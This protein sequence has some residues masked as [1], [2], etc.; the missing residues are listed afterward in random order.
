MAP[1]EGNLS[2]IIA[3]IVA[4]SISGKTCS[5][6]FFFLLPSTGFKFALSEYRLIDA[7]SDSCH[8]KVQ[9]K[10]LLPMVAL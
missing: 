8:Y 7:N 6:Q 1:R 10:A 5:L 9:L 4:F 3:P 2:L